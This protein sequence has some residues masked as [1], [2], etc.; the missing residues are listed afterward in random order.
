MTTTNK[1]DRATARLIP[2]DTSHMCDI[3]QR[4]PCEV[5]T[6]LGDELATYLLY[7][8]EIPT[9]QTTR[10]TDDLADIAR[11]KVITALEATAICLPSPDDRAFKTYVDHLMIAV[12]ARVRAAARYIAPNRRLNQVHR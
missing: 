11:I 5:L 2:A 12:E 1:R 7:L 8:T 9:N 3:D 10:L 6:P 4:Q